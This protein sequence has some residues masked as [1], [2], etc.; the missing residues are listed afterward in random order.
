MKKFFNAFLVCS[1]SLPLAAQDVEL[2]HGPKYQKGEVIESTVE[3]SVQQTLNIAGMDIET[4][5]ENVLTQQESVA[6]VTDTE[7]VINGKYKNVL[8]DISLP[9]GQKLQFDSGNPDA[10]LPEGQLRVL[11]EFIKLTSTAEWTSTLNAEGIVTS[12]KFLGDIADKAPEPFKGE[13]DGKK[14]IQ[15]SKQAAARLPGKSVSPGTTWEISEDIDLGSGQTFDV[16]R[17]MKFVGMEEHNGRQLAH[18]TVT[19]KSVK[20]DIKSDA[21]PLTVK[22][23]DLDAKS[24][25]GHLWYAPALKQV[26]EAEEELKVTGSL[27]LVANGAELPA[28]LDL[29]MKTK[30]VSDR[31]SASK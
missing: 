27:V 29:T 13:F 26:V 31:K 10:P 9:G 3:V 30:V 22:E 1:I 6:S 19:T 8:F 23:S 20:F 2:V 14:M 11:G 17:E 24:S 5:T 12:G 28:K 4:A 25:L 7:T 18:I 21:L 15:K 16:E